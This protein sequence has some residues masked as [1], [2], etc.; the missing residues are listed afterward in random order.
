MPAPGAQPRP[1]QKA[2]GEFAPKLAELTNDVLYGDVGN[3]C[4][5]QSVTAVW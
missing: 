3:G 4:N 5:Y 1:S 2:I